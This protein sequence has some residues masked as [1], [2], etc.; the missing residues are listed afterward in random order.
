ME[1]RPFL[2]ASATAL[3]ILAGG[4]LSISDPAGGE[5]TFTEDRTPTREASDTAT[6]TPPDGVVVEDIIVRNA[7]AYESTMGSG[8]VLADRDAQYVVATVRAAGELSADAFSFE[9]DDD[10]WDPGLPSTRGALNWAVAGHEGGAVGESAVG[11][12]R[13]YLA[14]AVPSPLSASNP[15]I[16]LTTDVGPTDSGAEWA[17]SADVRER[18]ETPGPRFELVELA[19]PDRVSHGE[20]LPVSLTCQNLTTTDGRFL[21][22]VH[23]PTERIV[24]DDEAHIVERDVAADETATATL[25]LDTEYTAFESGPVT[26]SVDGHVSAERQ[27]ELQD[28][29]TDE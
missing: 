29:P 11:G 28:V 2:A 24:D 9:T 21:A 19:V 16:R 23:W 26:L 12:V 13:S 1:R 25:E 7:V 8:G 15:R 14:F 18:L 4:C 20:T 17:L 5:P 6:L 27:V 3:G 10:S 22:A